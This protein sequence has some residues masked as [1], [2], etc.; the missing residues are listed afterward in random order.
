MRLDDERES[1]NFEDRRGTGGG[2]GR[3]GGIGIGTIVVGSGQALVLNDTPTNAGFFVR[4]GSLCIL[5]W[6]CADSV[7]D[8]MA[9][10]ESDSPPTDNP[11]PVSFIHPGGRLC[12][13]GAGDSGSELEYQPSA[14]ELAAGRYTVTT[15]IMKKPRTEVLIHRFD[16]VA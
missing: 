12:L 8:L 6:L 4:D 3:A 13:I 7:N 16:H 5:R 15:C 11:P 1:D 9:L 2:I 10:V 14:M